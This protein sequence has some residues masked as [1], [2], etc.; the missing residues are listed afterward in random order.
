M[1]SEDT[2]GQDRGPSVSGILQL[3][4]LPQETWTSGGLVTPPRAWEP[5]TLPPP[6]HPLPFGK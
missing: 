1:L 3:C 4:A 6:P 2:E 5:W